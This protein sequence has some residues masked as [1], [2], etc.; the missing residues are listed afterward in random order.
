MIIEDNAEFHE[1]EHRELPP[2]SRCAHHPDRA[3]AAACD[4]CGRPVCAECAP[5]KGG[6]HT[7]CRD[8][9]AASRLVDA[10]PA[11]LGAPAGGQAPP[12]GARR[13]GP[14]LYLLLAVLALAA[15]GAV[16]AWAAISGRLG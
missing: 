12:A 3:A 10:E 7:F 2:G 6:G 14:K 4:E 8:C 13:A 9:L 15:A 16:L 5:L 11:I 1:P